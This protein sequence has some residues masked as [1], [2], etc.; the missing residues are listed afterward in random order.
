M[1]GASR[2]VTVQVAS[3]GVL[4]AVVT[5]GTLPHTGAPIILYVAIAMAMLAA[6]GAGLTLADRLRYR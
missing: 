3:A 4:A 1:R 5:R 2:N 6:G